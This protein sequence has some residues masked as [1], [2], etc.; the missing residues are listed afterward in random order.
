MVL[1]PRSGV[2]AGD[3]PGLVGPHG[4]VARLVYAAEARTLRRMRRRLHLGVLRRVDARTRPV[5]RQLQPALMPNRRSS[6]GRVLC[7][8][9]A[10]S[11]L[12]CRIS[13]VRGAQAAFFTD[14]ACSVGLE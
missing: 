12:G 13:A 2:A 8:G 14:Y 6:D 4:P 11:Y 7:G 10:Y 1:G 5:T 3:P 9:A